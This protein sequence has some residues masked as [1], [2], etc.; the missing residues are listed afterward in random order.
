M[1]GGESL[2]AELYERAIECLSGSGW[3]HYEVSN[4]ARPGRRSRHNLVYWTR[5]PCLGLGPGASSFDGRERWRNHAGL[6]AYERAVTAGRDPAVEREAL[7]GE[8]AARER[9]IFG[10]RILE[11]IELPAF[12]AETGFPALELGGEPLRRWLAEGWVC[13]DRGRLKLTRRGL[14]ISDALWPELL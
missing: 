10:L 7:Q 3:E 14:M 11:G 5:R 9:L 6:I 1:T 12:A 4:F 2:S 13:L 8:A